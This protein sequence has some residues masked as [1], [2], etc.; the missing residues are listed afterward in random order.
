M[1]ATYSQPVLTISVTVGASKDYLYM[2][3]RKNGEIDSPSQFLPWLLPILTIRKCLMQNC[4][5]RSKPMRMN[6]ACA[7]WF[8]HA[9]QH[10]CADPSPLGW[11]FSV[12]VK[13]QIC[14]FRFE[15]PNE[16]VF[17]SYASI[18]GLLI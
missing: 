8:E 5:Q 6:L 18:N 4:L 12:Y 14:T 3:S 2:F 15:T 17:R 13:I 16:L 1:A 11:F 7:K 10:K 9:A